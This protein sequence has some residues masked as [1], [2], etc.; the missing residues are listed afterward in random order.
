MKKYIY[1]TL[2]MM[3]VTINV[4]AAS[5]TV[6]RSAYTVTKGSRVTFYINLN[7]LVAWDSLSANISGS[8]SNCSYNYDKSGVISMSGENGSK[9]YT[10]TCTATDVGQVGISVTGHYAYME[11][12]NKREGN[13][14]TGTVISVVKPRDP[15]SN[16]YLSSLEIEGYD[17]TPGFNAE[18]LEYTTEVPS[19]VDKVNIKATKASGYAQDPVG[20]GE[21]EV[22]EG[23]NNIEITVTSET[24]VSRTY[25]INVN[26][27]DDNPITTT[28]NNEKYTLMKNLKEM[29]APDG[30]EASKITINELEIP[31]FINETINITLVGI[32]DEKG[33]KVFASYNKDNNTYELFNY[34]KSERSRLFIQ[35]IKEELE[36]FHKDTITINSENYECLKHNSINNLI[37]VYAKD[38]TN[39]KDNY[40]TYDVD[41]STFILYHD[42]LE[43]H[44]LEELNKYKEVI[45]ILIGIIG[46]F[47]LIL[48]IMVIRRPKRRKKKELEEIR[49]EKVVVE[50]P[51]K[52]KKIIEKKLEEPKKETTKEETKKEES[53]P[54]ETMFDIMADNK[55]KKKRK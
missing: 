10:V 46:F 3:F 29:T 35:P 30:F 44:Y 38:L 5:I 28:I 45:A 52:E 32:K 33:N 12:G 51:K 25:K 34:T 41:T 17:L 36:N 53:V 47:A 18:T 4:H 20:V 11:G 22:T 1:F 23:S 49:E 26:V 6:G 50:T 16:N 48:I 8:A 37:V 31:V 24:G 14:S 21:H 9:T 42:D 27:K 2:I 15:D 55:K 39:G 40:Y 19:S 54:E 43:K 7:S 13:A